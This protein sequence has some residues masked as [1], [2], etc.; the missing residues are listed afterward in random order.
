[1]CFTSNRLDYLAEFLGV[2]RKIEADYGMLMN[3]MQGDAVTL[4]KMVKYNKQ[5]VVLLEIRKEQLF[6][7]KH[8][9]CEVYAKR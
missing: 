2:G 5:Y 9:T 1:M 4:K 8:V 6:I 3:T 7:G